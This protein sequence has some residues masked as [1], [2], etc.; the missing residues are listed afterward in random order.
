MLFAIFSFL[1][2]RFAGFRAFSVAMSGGQGAANVV[3]SKNRRGPVILVKNVG[4]GI[5]LQ[6]ITCLACY[7][8]RD[9][10]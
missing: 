5:R 3:D 8:F 2:L 9:D 1:C 7:S 6:E 4:Q 10:G